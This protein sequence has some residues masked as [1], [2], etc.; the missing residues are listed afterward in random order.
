MVNRI[1]T[2][3]AEMDMMMWIDSMLATEAYVIVNFT[4]YI[5]FYLLSQLL[6]YISYEGIHLNMDTSLLFYGM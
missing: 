1:V 5:I 4:P 3:D 2:L 6:E